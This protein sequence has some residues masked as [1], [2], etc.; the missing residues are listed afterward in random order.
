MHGALE[1][2]EA[3]SYRRGE[4]LWDFGRRKGDKK[5]AI[6]PPPPTGKEKDKTTK[7]ILDRKSVV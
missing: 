3:E 4:M 1:W 6:A 7:A 5:A 2:G